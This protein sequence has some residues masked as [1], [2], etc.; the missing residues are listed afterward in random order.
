ME[1]RRAVGGSM[2]IVRATVATC[3][4]GGGL[5]ERGESREVSGRGMEME[6][7]ERMYGRAGLEAWVRGRVDARIEGVGGSRYAVR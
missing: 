6:L 7:L 1:V 5:K 3:V 4:R 2:D